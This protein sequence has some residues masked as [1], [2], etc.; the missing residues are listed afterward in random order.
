MTI[1]GMIK[2]A[3]IVTDCRVSR[4]QRLSGDSCKHLAGNHPTTSSQVSID[5]DLEADSVA[6]KSRL[7]LADTVSTNILRR[8][9]CSCLLIRHCQLQCHDQPCRHSLAQAST[10][11]PAAAAAAAATANLAGPRIICACSAK[12]GGKPRG[13]RGFAGH[14]TIGTENNELSKVRKTGFRPALLCFRES[15]GFPKL[16]EADL[17]NRQN[18]PQPRLSFSSAFSLI[19]LKL[20]RQSTPL[21]MS[22]SPALS[23]FAFAGFVSPHGIQKDMRPYLQAT[24]R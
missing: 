14:H 17:M 6:S 21:F 11:F 20:V 10:D 8:N 5:K 23:L 13:R 4:P 7:V 3:R 1:L 19:R 22:R 9:D 24:E 18:G 2:T 16:G 15:P 12:I